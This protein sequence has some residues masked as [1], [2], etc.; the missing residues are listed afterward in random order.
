MGLYREFVRGEM[1]SFAVGGCGC[2]MG[3]GRKV[4]KLRDSI[5]RALWHLVFS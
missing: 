5:M 1:I 4:V 2:G 3:M